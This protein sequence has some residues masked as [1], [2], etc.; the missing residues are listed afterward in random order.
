[1]RK[2]EQIFGGILKSIFTGFVSKSS[3]KL[4]V[5]I[6]MAKKRESLNHFRLF[7]RIL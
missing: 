1:M 4:I 3:Y 6:S 7:N 5:S 2:S